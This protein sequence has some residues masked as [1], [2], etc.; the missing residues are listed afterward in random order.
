[1][2]KGLRTHLERFIVNLP[3][4]EHRHH[5]KFSMMVSC[6]RSALV[7]LAAEHICAISKS[8]VV[9]PHHMQS[10]WQDAVK[11]IIRLNESWAYEAP[12]LCRTVFVLNGL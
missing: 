3:G 1:M 11:D 4:F 9:H 12:D 5:G 7:L 10:L 2:S 6:T 8:T